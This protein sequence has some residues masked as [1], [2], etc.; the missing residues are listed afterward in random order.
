MNA[1]KPESLNAGQ[2]AVSVKDKRSE[3]Q[4]AM[5]AG[6]SGRIAAGIEWSGRDLYRILQCHRSRDRDKITAWRT[7][8]GIGDRGRP[9]PQACG[10]RRLPDA[11]FPPT[12]HVPR[13]PASPRRPQTLPA[14][15]PHPIPP[16]QRTSN[17]SDNGDLCDPPQTHAYL[18]ITLFRHCI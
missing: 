2:T 1:R 10:G 11:L 9:G 12:A 15:A 16:S 6:D 13:T 3:N 4:E 18:Q 17:S 14:R 8:S 5:L 7:R